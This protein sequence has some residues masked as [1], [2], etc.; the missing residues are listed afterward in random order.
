LIETSKDNS[1]IIDTKGS[2]QGK[3]VYSCNFEL[4]DVDKS[5]KL[6]SL[7]YETLNEL[8]GK[9]I[10]LTNLK[11]ASDIP[12]KYCYK[13]ICKYV[14]NDCGFETTVIEKMREPVFNYRGE[15]L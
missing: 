7:E 4:L 3:L 11:Q 13:T 2:I 6:N 10:K 14:S 5:T 12:E 8:I 1:P 15:H 9:N